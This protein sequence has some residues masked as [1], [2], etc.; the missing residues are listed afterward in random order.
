M[1]NEISRENILTLIKNSPLKDEQKKELNDLLTASGDAP[2]FWGKF[3]DMV[4]ASIENE[5]TA[6]LNDFA[7]IDEATEAINAK[8]REKERALAIELKKKL[9]TIDKWDFK[10]QEPAYAEFESGMDK[11][12][13]EA[14]KELDAYAAK[15][16]LK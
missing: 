3:T 9:E 13:S 11:V 5:K 10:A 8:V 12:I 2:E 1:T 4:T 14:K 7:A 6:M 15:E 16:I